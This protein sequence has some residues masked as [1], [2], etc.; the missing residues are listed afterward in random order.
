MSSDVPEDTWSEDTSSS[1]SAML[2]PWSPKIAGRE[3]P[4]KEEGALVIPA[5]SMVR[6]NPINNKKMSIQIQL[7]LNKAKASSAWHHLLLHRKEWPSQTKNQ[8]QH[9]RAEKTLKIICS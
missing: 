1:E 3:K 9:E 5:N 6:E 7:A 4:D 8:R 2:E